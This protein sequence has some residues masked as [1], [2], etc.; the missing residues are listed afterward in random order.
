[1]DAMFSSA[2]FDRRSIRRYTNQPVPH[3]VLESVLQAAIWAPSAHNRQPWRFA[4]VT[5]STVKEQLARRM[6]DQLRLD[7]Q[8]DS[9]PEAVIAADTAR[10]YA[11]I[12][13]APAVVILCLSMQD[14]D[15]YPDARRSQNEW[16]MAVQSTAMAGQNLLLAA[17][18]AGLGA[19]WMC[20]PLF[21]PLT[22]SA[23]LELPD[24]WQPQALITLGYPAEMKTKTR[25]PLEKSVVWR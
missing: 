19:C 18:A 15:S 10:S 1:M 22:V 2:L 8:A 25:H 7:L 13:S 9:A 12:T 6:G 5:D 3:E 11:R 16:V 20:A 21:S 17:H 24:D 23:V 4:V 14:M